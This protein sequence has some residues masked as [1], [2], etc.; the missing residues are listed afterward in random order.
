[1]AAK[2]IGEKIIEQTTL[3]VF[4]G[5]ARDFT[6]WVKGRMN[7]EVAKAPAKAARKMVQADQEPAAPV[8]KYD[9][10]PE[11]TAPGAKSPET[12]E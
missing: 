9:K 12:K 1:M 6:K 11:P 8:K 2:G 10:D 3:T 4:R 5:L 7:G